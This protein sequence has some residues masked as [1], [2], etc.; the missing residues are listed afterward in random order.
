[1]V[2][3]VRETV[4]SGARRL[5]LA[6]ADHQGQRPPVRRN[7]PQIQ[8]RRPGRRPARRSTP[9]T[10]TRLR[11]HPTAGISSRL[12]SMLEEV[13]AVWAA[14]STVA[15]CRARF[16]EVEPVLKIMPHGRLQEWVAHEEGYFTAEGLEYSFTPVSDYGIRLPARDEAGE[17]K[18]GA[19]ETF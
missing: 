14:R 8:A 10:A 7:H 16:E 6:A 19:F 1:M 18:T 17:I 3:R 9:L 15:R 11:W 4:R 13:D 12:A 2:V 5:R